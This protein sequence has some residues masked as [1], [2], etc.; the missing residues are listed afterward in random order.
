MMNASTIR[1]TLSATAVII[2]AT[3]IHADSWCGFLGNRGK[4]TYNLLAHDLNLI[5]TV[6]LCKEAQHVRMIFVDSI[7]TMY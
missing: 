7:L 5:G 6:A 4:R 3:Y 2:A 1:L